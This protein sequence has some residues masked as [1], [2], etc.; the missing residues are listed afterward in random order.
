MSTT[1]SRRIVK[2]K[3]EPLK[4]FKH[5]ENTPVPEECQDWSSPGEEETATSTGPTSGEETDYDKE[6]YQVKWSWYRSICNK[7]VDLKPEMTL[8]G[9]EEMHLL[10]KWYGPGGIARDAFQQNWSRRRIG[11]FWANPPFSR[12]GPVINKIIHDGGRGILVCPRW[13][14]RDWYP[15]LME[16]AQRRFYIDKGTRLFQG[17]KG[18][19]GPTRWGTWTVLIDGRARVPPEK[20][21]RDEGEDDFQYRPKTMSKIRR[22]RRKYR[23]ET[24]VE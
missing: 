11:I 9:Y 12:L 22:Q 18:N 10:G 7:L 15:K 4:P 1:I 16:Y 21:M 19:V 5:R 17:A 13:P 20:R 6:R 24:V 14:Q 23:L 8:F 2:T 3:Y